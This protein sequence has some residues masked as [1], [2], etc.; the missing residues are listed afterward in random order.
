MTSLENTVF[1]IIF[2]F[3]GLQDTVQCFKLFLGS[4]RLNRDVREPQ[5]TNKFNVNYSCFTIKNL[6]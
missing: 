1:N 6:K 5:L 3:M 2:L 4:N